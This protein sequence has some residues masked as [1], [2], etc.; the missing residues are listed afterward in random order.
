VKNVLKKKVIA[1]LFVGS[2]RVR[3]Q[4]DGQSFLWST[5]LQEYLY[6]DAVGFTIDDGSDGSQ[7]E[8]I[9]WVNEC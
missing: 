6:S 9:F 8:R 1:V 2:G 7:S 5:F 3:V 4:M